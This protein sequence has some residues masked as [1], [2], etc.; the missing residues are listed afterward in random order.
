MLQAEKHTT[1]HD[2]SVS[3]VTKGEGAVSGAARKSEADAST[4]KAV[5]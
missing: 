2:H 5:K 1:A 4:G 3:A